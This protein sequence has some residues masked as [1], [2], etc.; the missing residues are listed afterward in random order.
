[1]KRRMLQTRA[2]QS[3]KVVW[4]V[5]VLVWAGLFYVSYHWKLFHRVEIMMAGAENPAPEL[6]QPGFKDVCDAQAPPHGM[7][8][9][10]DAESMRRH[11]AKP[12]WLDIENRHYFPVMALLTSPEGDVEYLGVYLQQGAGTRL[13]VPVGDYGLAILTGRDWCNFETGFKDGQVVYYEGSIGAREGAVSSMRLMPV[14]YQEK[15]VMFSFN[16]GGLDQARSSGGTLELSRQHNGHFHVAGTVNG[17]PVTFMIDTGATIVSI[18]YSVARNLGLDKNCTPGKFSTAAGLVQG[19]TSIAAELSFG[20]FH[21]RQLE[22]SFNQGGE[23]ALMGMN[24]LSQF[25]IQQDAET[26]LISLE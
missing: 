10:A 25:R 4:L 9:K 13:K 15:D 20:G 17:Y 14:G 12:A 26:M 16:P 18:P 8:F 24:V 21:L 22:V 23:Q 2:T 19:C 3:G 7:R 6:P 1:M 11:N 5:L